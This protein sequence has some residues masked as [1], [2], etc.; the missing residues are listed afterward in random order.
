MKCNTIETGAMLGR[1]R[2]SADSGNNDPAELPDDFG[3]IRE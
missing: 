1:K 3:K 2:V